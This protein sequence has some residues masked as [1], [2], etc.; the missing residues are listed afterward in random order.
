R[1]WL[2]SGPFY[3]H[4]AA[5]LGPMLKDLDALAATP[6]IRVDT[7]VPPPGLPRLPPES[8]AEVP[9]AE[10]ATRV[11]SGDWWVHSFS[12]LTR[13]TTG[14]EATAAATLAVPGGRDAPV[15]PDDR[16]PAAPVH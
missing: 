7:T 5:A 9:P 8:D 4:D 15:V 3:N 6:G 12:G 13:T 10:V 2:A 11:L 14:D 16:L 1:M